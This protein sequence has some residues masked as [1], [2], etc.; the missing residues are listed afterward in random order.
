M[1]NQSTPNRSTSVDS[2]EDWLAVVKQ[3]VSALRFGVVQ[4]V[5]HEGR[6]VQIECTE[7]VRLDRPERGHE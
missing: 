3:K 6:V 7:K 5:V 2:A 4:V 1:N